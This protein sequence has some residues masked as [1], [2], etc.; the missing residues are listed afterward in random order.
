MDCSISN[1]TM[2]QQ[3]QAQP[4]GTDYRQGGP[5]QCPPLDAGATRPIGFWSGG[6]SCEGSCGG[7]L[8]CQRLLLGLN[9]LPD[10]SFGVLTEGVKKAAK[11]A[12]H[13]LHVSGQQ[14]VV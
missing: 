5:G 14:K 8:P 9:G 1:D 11:A 3:P 2:L 6:V 12:V 13:Q 4:V 7:M 10:C